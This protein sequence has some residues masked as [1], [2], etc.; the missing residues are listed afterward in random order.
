M[1]RCLPLALASFFALAPTQAPGAPPE[2]AAAA[3]DV[4]LR[5]I[6]VEA[7]GT[8]G[9]KVLHV[10]SGRSVGLNAGDRFPMASVYKLPIAVVVLA[11]VDS[12]DLT[13]EQQVEVKPGELRRTASKVDPW[14]PGVRVP[15]AKL[16]DA[17]L[18]ESDNTA[19]DV[20]L[21]LLGGPR[22]VDAWLDAHGFPGIDVTWTELT[23]AAVSSGVVELPRDGDCDY[24]CL[25]AL[26]VK[27]PKS[28]REAAGLAFERDRRNTASPDDLARFLVALHDGKLL[29]APSTETLLAMMRR[30]RTGDRRIRALLPK[31]TAVWDKTGTMDGIANDIGFVELPGGKGTARRRGAREGLTARLRLA[32]KGYREGRAGGVRRLRA[33]SLPGPSPLESTGRIPSLP[34]DRLRTSSR[35]TVRSG[36]TRRG[37]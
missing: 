33:L 6:A 18:T 21:R 15:L 11:K 8:V 3:L 35:A 36:A 12:R 10:E 26:V 27:V 17:M 22:A 16:L 13:L 19:C 30:N 37:V 31:G 5:S 28:A 25:D 1:S 32:R 29:A 23:M 4:D 7:G 34:E 9:V 14:T 2:G 20:L 24:R